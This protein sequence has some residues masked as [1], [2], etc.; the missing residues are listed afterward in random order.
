MQIALV[1]YHCSPYSGRARHLQRFAQELQARGHHCRIYAQRWQ[2]PR[3][4]ETEVRLIAA[5]AIRSHRREHRFQQQV[6]ADLARDPVDG[7]VGFEKMPGLDVY[8]AADTCYLDTVLKERSAFYRRSARFNHYLKCERTV[9]APPSRTR[10]LLG[11]P[12]T[13]RI[14]VQ[15]YGTEASRM[16]LLPPGVSR[17]RCASD[18]APNQR[19]RLR[20]ALDLDA[21]E[22]TLLFVASSFRD[23]GLD[24]VLRAQAAMRE[25]QPNAET[26]LLVVGE[27]KPGRYRRLA[28][29]L[30]LGGA[31]DFLG[32]RDDMPELL[33][34]ADLLVHPAVS[35]AAGGI[36]L[37]ALVAGLPV[38]AT[39][40][41]GYAEHIASANAGIV[42]RDP[43]SQRALNEALLRCVD[44]VFRAQCGER[45]LYYA[46]RTDLFSMHARGADFILAA[47][48]DKLAAY[49]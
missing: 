27:D 26:R 34:A 1:I 16:H 49:G 22:I 41:C 15:H 47:V 20:A 43:F 19:R 31:V 6:L 12:A 14:F 25:Q 40:V 28:R 37:E 39:S 29:R 46:Q 33:Q 18:D 7:V 32:P 24:R 5:H 45:G 11:S 35:D 17:D 13:Q 48:Q 2:G 8:F 21:R 3:P 30:G 10:L 4:A 23:K 44:G 36:L 9:V 38:V 42:L